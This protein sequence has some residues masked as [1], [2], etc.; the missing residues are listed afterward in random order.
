[1]PATRIELPD[2]SRRFNRK[3]ELIRRNSLSPYQ[4]VIQDISGDRVISYSDYRD[5]AISHAAES[6]EQILSEWERDD[7]D[8]NDRL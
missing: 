1:M 6:L 7:G 2:L 4:V 8:A 5:L 3:V